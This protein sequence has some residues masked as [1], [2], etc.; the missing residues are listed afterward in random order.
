LENIDHILKNLTKI[1]S[2]QAKPLYI[3]QNREHVTHI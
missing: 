1:L 3:D 2:H